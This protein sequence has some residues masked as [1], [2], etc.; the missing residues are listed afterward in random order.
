MAYKKKEHIDLNQLPLLQSE[1]SEIVRMNPDTFYEWNLWRMPISFTDKKKTGKMD[2]LFIVLPPRNVFT[3]E[4]ESAI[5]TSTWMVSPN[6]STG[7]AGPFDDAVLMAVS[8]IITELPKPISNPIK[9]GSLNRI[10]KILKYNRPSQE[11]LDAIKTSLKRLKSLIITS[12]RAF[13]LKDAGIFLGGG[14]GM[15]NLLDKVVFRNEMIDGLK[16]DDN[17]IWL[18]EN[19]LT[20]LNANYVIPFDSEFYFKLNTPTARAL[21]KVLTEI[22]FKSANRQ[23]EI[24]YS[25][26]CNR[27]SITKR[28]YIDLA[29][30][31]LNPSLDELKFLGI[32]GTYQYRQFK[33]TKRDWGILL[34]KGPTW[35]RYYEDVHKK[36]VEL[37]PDHWV[38]LKELPDDTIKSNGTQQIECDSEPDARRDM[39]IRLEEISMLPS[40]IK[41]ILEHFSDG[42]I[43]VYIDYYHINAGKKDVN[44][45]WLF[46][47]FEKADKEDIREVVKNYWEAQRRKDIESNH[48]NYAKIY[49]NFREAEFKK[50]WGTL[51][52]GEKKK[53]EEIARSKFKP[54]GSEKAQKLT[55][56]G[57]ISKIVLKKIDFPTFEEWVESSPNT[58]LA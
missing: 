51:P 53:I 10:A 1:S 41:W 17:M 42:D 33:Y 13:Y 55:L 46:G 48:D 2:I 57:I 45:R 38:H 21:L 19:L 22:F 30:Q 3:A 27:T 58:G 31:Q 49:Q 4:G 35:L 47:T 23:V 37:H 29:E 8:K 43:K 5:E 39:I 54:Y 56:D 16:A 14:E 20:N 34:T 7:A 18:P 6:A 32:I 12:D 26:L 11:D 52:A 44:A 28:K 50:V 24:V 36:Y 25:D 15:F 9:I 40:Q